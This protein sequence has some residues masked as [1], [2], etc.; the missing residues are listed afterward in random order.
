MSVVSYKMLSD[1]GNNIDNKPSSYDDD[2]G[3]NKLNHSKSL[4]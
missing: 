1:E 4:Y 2:D 3:N